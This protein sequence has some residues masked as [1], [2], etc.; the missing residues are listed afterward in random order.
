MNSLSSSSRSTAASSAVAP[1]PSRC[2]L[3]SASE[4]KSSKLSLLSRLSAGVKMLMVWGAIALFSLA[5]PFTPAAMATGIYDLDPVQAGEPTWV[6]DQ[7]DVLSRFSEGQLKGRLEKISEQTGTE[8]RFIVF[9]R[10]DYG[11]TIESFTEQLFGAWFP[12]E[13]AA[14]NQ[15]LIA[16][17]TQTNTI[18]V[19]S[20]SEVKPFLTDEIA[21]SVSEETMMAPIREGDKYNQ[22]L[23]DASDRLALV[24][25][26]EEDPGPPV[27]EDTLRVEGTFASSEETKE[28][29]ATTIVIILLIVATVVPM[30]TYFAYVR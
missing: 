5:A 16:L 3:R 17:D 9:R 22:S 12:N 14:A 8:V 18:A 6:V 21:A 19:E 13:E 4:F 1:N 10:L 24:L 23:L 20:G 7:A 25:A 2:E 28:S 27:I 29:N 15:V 30:L 26:G 11:E